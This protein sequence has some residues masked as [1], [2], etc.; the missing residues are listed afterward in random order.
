ME[1]RRYWY[2]SANKYTFS[3]TKITTYKYL[4]AISKYYATYITGDVDTE[5]FIYILE[6]PHLNE[7]I[8]LFALNR[9]NHLPKVKAN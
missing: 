6:D 8:W 1:Q 2:K 7:N 5:Q 4:I 3:K 9:I